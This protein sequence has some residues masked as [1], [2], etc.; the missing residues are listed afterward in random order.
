M[1]TMI[2]AGAVVWAALGGT[3]ARAQSAPDMPVTAADRARIIDGVAKKLTEGYVF[4]DRAALIAQQLAKPAVRARYN[5][6][7]T[8]SA[9]TE[10][11]TKDLK[12]WSKDRHLRVGFSTKPRPIQA[13]SAPSAEAQ[14][15]A[16]ESAQARNFGFH[17]VERLTGNVG[18][19]EIGRFAPA[20]LAAQTLAAA[21]QM[22]SNTDALI[23][24]LRGSGGGS[25][26]FV[27]FMASYFLPEQT[28]LMTL[29]RRK[30]AADQ[31]WSQSYVPGPRYLGK[32]IYV[33]TSNFTFSGA[34]GLTYDL[35]HFAGAVV[36]GEKTRGGANPGS[37]QQIDEHF[38][39][40]VPT[41]RVVHAATGTN[42]DADG[43]APDHAVVAADAKK[44][45]HR[46]A[47]EKLIASKGTGERAAMW[48]EAMNELFSA[49][50][51]AR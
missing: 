19:M 14:A 30:G 36:V 38:G 47:L 24:D 1:R 22:L 3:A 35:K 27:A 39:V 26:D 4:E 20:A 46:L 17:Q 42:W 18:Y 49:T 9:F 11:L 43:I 29:E 32:P 6:L 51:S 7:N 16:L 28:H 5:T 45:A 25:V 15:H 12:A 34:E 50:T 8:A 21:M 13:A 2:L 40:F 44:T 37:I 48:Q 31:V 33:L 23:I 41:A 10:A